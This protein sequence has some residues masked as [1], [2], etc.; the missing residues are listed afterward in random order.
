MALITLDGA[1]SELVFAIRFGFLVVIALNVYY[2]WRLSSYVQK[3]YKK[4]FFSAFVEESLNFF[5]NLHPEDAEYCRL[6]RRNNV[7]LLVL[8]LWFPVSI[9]LFIILTMVSVTIAN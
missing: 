1:L 3:K 7:A 8:I 6:R 4:S 5:K 2:D 9:P